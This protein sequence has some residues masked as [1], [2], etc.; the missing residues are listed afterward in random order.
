MRVRFRDDS[1]K[2]ETA[3]S[4]A[5]E[6]VEA[7]APTAPTNLGATAGDTEVTL[8][9]DTPHADAAITGHEYRYKTDGDYPDMWETIDDS[10]PGG[11]HEDGV[12]V[13]GLD[14][15]RAYTFQVRAVNSAGPSPAS[16]EAGATPIPAIVIEA[17]ART[18]EH[19]GTVQVCA[20]ASNTSIRPITVDLTIADGTATNPEDYTGAAVSALRIQPSQAKSC[21]SV[22]VVDD[23]LNEEDEDFTAT[24]SGPVNA[25]LG[26]PASVSLTIV[27]NDEALAVGV[28]VEVVHD[29][30][31]VTALPENAGTATI[32]VTASTNVNRAPAGAIELSVSSRDGTAAGSPS[33]DSSGDYTVVSEL[34]SYAASEFSQVPGEQHYAA[35]KTLTLTIND[36]TLVEEDET[37]EL[38]TQRAPDTPAHVTLS[39]PLTITIEDDDEPLALTVS[40]VAGDDTINIAEKAAGFDIAG[41]GTAGASV[42]VT[43]GGTVRGTATADN[44]GAWS[45]AVPPNAAYIGGDSVMLEVSA[46]KAGFTDATAVSR[47]L[48]I[49]LAAPTASYTAPAALKVGQAMTPL[50][51]ATTA[52]DI[53]GYALKAGSTLP[54]G[55]ALDTASGHIV[56]TPAAA[57]AAAH[58]TTVTVTDTAG[59]PGEAAIAFPA[60]AKGDQ[61]LTGFAYSPAMV[62]VGDD[63]P[64]LTAPE[65]A[66]GALSYA[67]DTPAVCTVD[68]GSGALTIVAAG[69]CTVRATAAATADYVEASDTFTVTV[70]AAG[71]L[72]LTLALTVS[73]VTG[74]DTINITEKA[75]GFDIGGAT[76]SES[77]VAVSVSIGTETLSATSSSADPA[78]WSVRVPAN[79]AYVSGTSVTL[80]VSA[81]KAGFTDAAPVSRA[82]TIDLA[83]PAASYTAPVALKVGQAITPLAPATTDTDIDGYALAGSTLPP[84]LTL[85]TASGR[86]DGAPTAASAATHATT[87]TVT[88]RAGN[89]GEAEIIF[90]A[91]AKGDQTL[92]G[93]AYG[94]ADI[95]YGDPAPTLT[96]PTG[97]RGALSYA[98]DTPAVCTVDADNGALTILAAG[99]CRL[100]VTAAATPDYAEASD[101]FT[102]TV[103]AAGTLALTVSAVAGDDTI[104]IAEKAAGFD[105]GGTT[106]FEGGVAVSVTIGT[107]TLSATSSS[108]DPATWSVSVPADAAY[109]T[110]TSVA[111]QV[112]A[113]K[114]GFTDATPVSRT[115]TVDLEAPTASYTAPAAL[116][117]DQAL[118]LDPSTTDTDIAVYAVKAGS[119][120]PPGLALDTG[121]GRIDGA[122]TAASAAAHTTTVAFTDT[123]GNP[124]EADI[125]F[126]A[127]D[128]GEQTLTGFAYG[129][130]DI[131]YGDPAPTLTA[132]T[133]ARGTL[134]YTSDTPTVCTV[135]PDSGALTILAAGS[136]TV[137]ATAAATA[138]Y[139]EGQRHL[140]GGGAS[141]G[142]AGADR[143]RRD[144]RRH[145]QYRG[146]GGGL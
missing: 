123:A 131:T 104:N 32:R 5:T 105:I 144:R 77:G 70:Q 16:N 113:S 41:T 24:L 66:R 18:D 91:V 94:P 86:I 129:P 132:P 96:A 40:A 115:L 12:D 69:S 67:S 97:A 103:Q 1:G 59:N 87:V 122:P 47:A 139:A 73:D 53:D 68:P 60:V 23:E 136:C 15:G 7:A 80:E 102:V 58:T 14:N 6:A 27:D 121:S 81:S 33:G 85:D 119:T 126:P 118:T 51:P 19:A 134:G 17:D 13:T 120:L 56:G 20:V 57:S 61:T 78:T 93:F 99:S 84:G 127:V 114:A 138:D 82:L 64:A 108:A 101:T 137:R 28:A 54:P 9:W 35:T 26:T 140:H 8:S 46:S 141:G 79:A 124:G 29:N 142:H 143:L 44:D 100:T 3:I 112:S 146:E 43:L 22:T 76:G 117:V 39:E 50:A 2:A 72:A 89:P 25:T 34:L 135:D 107:A 42:T 31:A 10:A 75:S 133:G 4:A 36:D 88:D 49:D 21:I 55:L 38:V 95:T 98:S 92:T 45:F 128:K 111:L 116:K 71:E 106:G 65:G 125:A 74:D 52:T 110:G 48:T 30:A 11:D 37:F 145:D 130:A 109:I 62:T 90:P 63:A 83:V